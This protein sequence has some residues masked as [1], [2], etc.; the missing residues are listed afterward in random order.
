MEEVRNNV[1][2]NVPQTVSNDRSTA[3]ADNSEP[4]EIPSSEDEDQH[5]VQS[6]K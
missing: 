2:Q 4:G 5:A 1:P 3:A 6:R